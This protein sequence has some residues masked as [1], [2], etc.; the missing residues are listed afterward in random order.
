MGGWIHFHSKEL[1]NCKY[2]YV[3]LVA[4]CTLLFFLMYNI[5]VIWVCNLCIL[6]KPLLYYFNTIPALVGLGL[7]TLG[8]IGLS[9]SAVMVICCG[10]G[11][12][13]IWLVETVLVKADPLDGCRVAVVVLTGLSI[14]TLFGDLVV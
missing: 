8:A 9:G 14:V 10:A 7:A 4:C 6:N 2:M 3:N 1:I 13:C 12:T 11:C 5:N